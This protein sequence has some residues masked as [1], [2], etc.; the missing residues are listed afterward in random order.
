MPK[1]QNPNKIS[2]G[3]V[4]DFLKNHKFF[5]VMIFMTLLMV[6]VFCGITYFN[7][8]KAIKKHQLLNEMAF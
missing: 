3:E 5:W 1:P 7:Q 2:L 6:F 8:Q 4:F